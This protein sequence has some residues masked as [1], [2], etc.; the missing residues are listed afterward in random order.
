MGHALGQIAVVDQSLGV[1]YN[2]YVAAD[3]YFVIDWK[4][5]RLHGPLG[6]LE[7][8]KEN[9]KKPDLVTFREAR[10]AVKHLVQGKVVVGHN[11][12]CDLKFLNPYRHSAS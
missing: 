5:T 10:L 9:D 8:R 7:P 2:R 12:Q 11:L 1:L 6:F 4:M 3:P